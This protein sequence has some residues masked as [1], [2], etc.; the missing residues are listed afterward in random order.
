MSEERRKPGPK[1]GWKNREIAPASVDA[2]PVEAPAT[3]EQHVFECKQEP[4]VAVVDGYTMT[5]RCA[6]CKY[7]RTETGL[8]YHKTYCAKCDMQMG[9]VDKKK[10]G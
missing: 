7:T 10:V 4:V 6:G 5:F 2:I 3:V 1:P 8:V 9:M